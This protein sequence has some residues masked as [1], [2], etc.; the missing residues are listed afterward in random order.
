VTGL[1][2]L[3][4]VLGAVVAAGLW[5]ARVHNGLVR[6]RH[7]VHESWR[8]IDV[9]LTR[10]HELVPN[11]VET[12]SPHLRHDPQLVDDVVRAR[13][14]ALA[15]GSARPRRAEAETA[16]TEALDRLFAV[17]ARY[18]VLSANQNLLALQ[19]EL[20]ETQDRVAA[21]RR[22]YNANVAELNDRVAAWP[23]RPFAAAFG[24]R[25]AEAFE[26]SDP[27]GPG[28]A[29]VRFDRPVVPGE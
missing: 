23:G 15:A 26:L 6:L 22:F 25:P 8:Q 28:T 27:A 24:F 3:V 21:G 29:A 5:A 19:E 9:E 10:R 16:L 2:A 18:P 14:A 12:V 11:L 7:L 4:A 17:T 1:V 13:A 20:G